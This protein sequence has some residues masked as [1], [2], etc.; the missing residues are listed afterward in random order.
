M[1]FIRTGTAEQVGYVTRSGKIEQDRLDLN[2]RIASD[3][4]EP[5]I[6]YTQSPSDVAPDPDDVASG[7]DAVTGG[8]DL[9]GGGVN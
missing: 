9:G 8:N 3:P 4:D 7:A 1:S 2:V 5:V 6:I